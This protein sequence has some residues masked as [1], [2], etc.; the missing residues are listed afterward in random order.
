MPTLTVLPSG[1]SYPCSAG[2]TLLQA[3]MAAG[4]PI[5]HKCEGKAQC[6]S[7]H[8]HVLEGSAGLSTI[9]RL[10][11]AKL[12]RIVGVSTRSRLAC[13]AV[14]GEQPVTVELLRFV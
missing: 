4:E 13:Q 10:E 5:R 12:D 8:L 3:L 7:C 11:G 6:E 9:G 14:L 2:S 1:K